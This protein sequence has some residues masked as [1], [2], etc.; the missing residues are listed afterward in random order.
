MAAPTPSILTLELERAVLRELV[1][2]YE[3]F[4]ASLFRRQLM[5]PG[6]RLDPVARSLGEWHSSERLMVFS[7][8]FVFEQPWGAVQEVLKHEMAHQFVDE[9]LGERAEGPHGATFREVC[10]ARGIDPAATGIPAGPGLN[11][12]SS[13]ILERIR[14][15]L[16]LAKSQD[17]HEAEAAAAAARRLMLKYDLEHVGEGSAPGMSF[18]HLGVPTGR[19]DEAA[20]ILAAILGEF[21]FVQVIWIPVWRPLEAKRGSVLEVCGTPEHLELASY[22]H[23]FLDETAE[24]LWLDYRRTSAAKGS[25][26]RRVFRAGVMAGFRERLKEER[27]E[28]AIVGL[29]WVGDPAVETYMRQ[30][31][32]QI[33]WVRSAAR[34]RPAAFGHGREA[35]RDI[36]LRSPLRSGAAAGPKLLPGR[37]R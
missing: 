13:H 35:G 28:Q 6:F 22:V 3:A 16:A 5:L 24:R 31:H 11:Q 10:G 2:E 27:R 21:Y 29:V 18:R 25:G 4:A 34:T 19:V 32:P 33:R 1:S 30:R 7:R 20:R 26:P 9:V 12:S 8:D 36:Q 23:A 15:L 14:K 37:K 17:I